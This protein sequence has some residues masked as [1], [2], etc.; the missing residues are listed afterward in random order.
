MLHR[1]IVQSVILLSKEG[2]ISGIIKEVS[3]L[4]TP[5]E[6]YDHARLSVNPFRVN[7]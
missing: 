4:W 2:E 1:L 3:C 6:F 7:L 5:A